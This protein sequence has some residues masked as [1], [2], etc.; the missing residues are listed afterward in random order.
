MEVRVRRSLI[1][2]ALLAVGTLTLFGSHTS[3]F[4]DKD[5]NKDNHDKK[6][7]VIH[8]DDD[9]RGNNQRDKDQR[10]DDDRRHGTTVVR[11]YRIDGSTPFTQTVCGV[12]FSGILVEHQSYQLLSNG[13]L[14]FSYVAFVLAQGTDA[15]GNRVFM[16]V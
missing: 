12:A 16:V 15:H 5:G 6:T 2:F 10:D 8:R 14:N 3:A 4:A 9:D 7:V 1:L 13:M 11:E